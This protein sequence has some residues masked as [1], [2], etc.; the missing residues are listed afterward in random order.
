METKGCPETSVATDQH[1]VTSRK[2]DDLFFHRDRRMKSRRSSFDK[3]DGRGHG[4]RKGILSVGSVDCFP[5][6]HR[7]VTHSER[8]TAFILQFPVLLYT[9]QFSS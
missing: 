1:C 6:Q 5:Y 9:S 8:M 3:G 7:D 4:G 2:I